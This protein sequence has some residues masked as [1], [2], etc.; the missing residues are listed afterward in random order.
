MDGEP[1]EIIDKRG[2]NHRP[3]KAIDRVQAAVLE[4]APGPDAPMPDRIHYEVQKRTAEALDGQHDRLVQNEIAKG[5]YRGEVVD[6]VAAEQR[7]VSNAFGEAMTS[8]LGH[9]AK[10]GGAL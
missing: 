6:A 9:L 2:S 8:V 7:A 10:N 1:V 5:F 3:G 4:P